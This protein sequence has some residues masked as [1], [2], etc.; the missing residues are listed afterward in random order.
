VHNKEVKNSNIDF[1][2]HQLIKKVRLKIPE[3]VFFIGDYVSSIKFPISLEFPT[4]SDY[5][6]L[7]FTLRELEAAS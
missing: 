5:G 7:V 3:C 1:V 6:N 2:T 4:V